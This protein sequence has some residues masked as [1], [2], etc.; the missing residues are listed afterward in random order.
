MTTM[1]TNLPNSFP[2]HL[3]DGRHADAGRASTIVGD[4]VYVRTAYDFTW[5]IK[6]VYRGE[7]TWTRSLLAA[8]LFTI[9]AAQKH[10]LNVGNL[11]LKAI[12][13]ETEGN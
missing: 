12:Q 10:A 5:Y 3:P 6:S 9:S 4:V 2:A 13:N 11:V 7:Y 1:P 8:K